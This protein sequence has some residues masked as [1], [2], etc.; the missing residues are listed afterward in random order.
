[1]PPSVHTPKITEDAGLSDVI[2]DSVQDAP[3]Q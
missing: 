3:Q 2:G 1:M